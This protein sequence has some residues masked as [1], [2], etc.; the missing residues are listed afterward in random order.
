MGGARWRGFAAGA[1][2]LALLGGGCTYSDRE[3]GLFGRTP[4]AVE[5]P[6][7]S[8][9][10]PPE[11]V[12][13]IPL[14]GTATWVSADAR[15]IPVR[16]AVHGIRRVPGGAVLDWSITTLSGPDRV[17]G[18]PVPEGWSV[19]LQEQTDVALVDPDGRVYRPLV[20]RDAVDQC[21]CVPVAQA[22]QGLA[23]D[24]PRL[25]QVAFPALPT[26]LRLVD[27]AIAVAPVISRVPVAP[28]GQV[29]A[30][31][32]D[33]DLAVP[34]E[35][36]PPLART[37]E[38]R[39]PGGQRFVLEVGAV[40]ASGTLTSVVW[41]LEAQSRG[42]GPPPGLQPTLARND[43]R[44]GPIRV[45]Q[46]E[47]DDGECLCSD[48]ARWQDQLTE[49]G[50]RVTVVTTLDEIPRGAT[51]VD[52][53]FPDL[54]PLTDIP[55]RPA[56]DAALRT[57]GTVDGPSRTWTPRSGDPRRGWALRSWPTPVPVIAK[58]RY[59]ATVDRIL[60]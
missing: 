19:G 34:A 44:V 7:E 54:R 48:P 57:A 31:I 36:P 8:R 43:W 30:P 51:N 11:S 39:L 52:V 26:E 1:L 60:D 10:D 59:L 3:S 32:S 25:L 38:F 42:P 15:G 40:L 46:A 33:A 4:D 13:P 12:G 21:L 6:T 58:G 18:E 28:L 23:Y 5:S 47:P 16:F 24:V 55:V 56:S 14:L 22:Q 41:T 20:A 49:P 50:R 35:L 29:A 27:V 9:T 45:G 37:P 17:S 53:L 2:T